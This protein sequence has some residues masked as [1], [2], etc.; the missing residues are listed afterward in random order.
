MQQ[1]PGLGNLL[2]F[3]S[4]VEVGGAIMGDLSIQG[5]KGNWDD[6]GTSLTFE[7]DV[8]V[9]T[10]DPQHI[11]WCQFSVR[12]IRSLTQGCTSDVLMSTQ[13]EPGPPCQEAAGKLESFKELSILS[14]G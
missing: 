2:P 9:I 6:L 8:M 1:V 14:F 11:S 3:C 12:W 5:A 10:T 13:K 7:A 4:E